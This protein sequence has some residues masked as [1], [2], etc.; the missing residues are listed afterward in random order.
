MASSQPREWARSTSLVRNSFLILL[1]VATV[2][3]VIIAFGTVRSS[4][5]AAGAQAG[6]IP[7]FTSTPEAATVSSVVFLG[8]SYIEGS[9]QDTGTQFPDIISSDKGWN[10][11]MLGE[12]GSGYV[13]AGN[14]GTTFTDR[15][16]KAIAAKPNMVVV[17]G[18]F[19]DKDLSALPAAVLNVLTTLRHSLP[20]NVPVVVFS[21]FVPS[22][23][24]SPTDLQKHD[25][26]KQAAQ[27]AGVTFIDVTGAFTGHTDLIGTDHTHPTDAGHKYLANLI[28]PQLPAPAPLS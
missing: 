13:T 19:N 9:T 27:K 28:E 20:A 15:V 26:I 3:L 2:C 23:T 6:P 1:A 25:I 11:V 21:N 16:P 4:E 7:T 14:G 10:Q 12:G 5:P 22:G 8:D 18:G 17:S 24:P